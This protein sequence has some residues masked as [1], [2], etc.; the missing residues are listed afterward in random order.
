MGFLW[1]VVGIVE[2]EYWIVSCFGVFFVMGD[3][4]NW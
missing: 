3:K 1:S 4:N 2:L